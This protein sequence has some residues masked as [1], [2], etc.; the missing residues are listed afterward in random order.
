M[1]PYQRRR[2]WNLLALSSGLIFVSGGGV[3]LIELVTSHAIKVHWPQEPAE[4]L[5][6]GRAW[7][8]TGATIVCGA[9]TVWSAMRE[10]RKG[11]RL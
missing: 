7:L 1:N 8:A 3:L 4:V 2:I 10:L 11:S 9:G 5:S 6:G